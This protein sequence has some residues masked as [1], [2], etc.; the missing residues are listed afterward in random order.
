MS[1]LASKEANSII[2]IIIIIGK[3]VDDDDDDND[4][5]DNNNKCP[6]YKHILMKCYNSGNIHDPTG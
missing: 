4:D 1:E 6:N 2:I 5:D 3:L